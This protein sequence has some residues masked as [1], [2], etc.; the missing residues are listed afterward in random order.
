MSVT[1]AS[2]RA[3]RRRAVENAEHSDYRPRNSLKAQLHQAA[4]D[5]QRLCDEVDRLREQLA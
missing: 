1:A 5:V 2:L 3:M 4:D